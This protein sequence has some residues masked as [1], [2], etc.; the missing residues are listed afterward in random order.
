MLNKYTY[1]YYS[2]IDKAKS[3]KRSKLSKDSPRYIYY[4]SHH[5]TPISLGGSNDK[6]NLVLLTAKEHFICHLLLCKMTSGR[7]KC[8]MVN[9]L[10]K[11]QYSKS[12]GQKRYTSKSF[13]LIRTLISE[14]NSITHKGKRKSAETRKRMSES[15]KGIVFSES[16]RKNIGLATKKRLM[17][18]SYINPATTIESREKNK[19]FRLENIMVSNIMTNECKW[20]PIEELEIYIQKGFKKGNLNPSTCKGRKWFR[21]ETENKMFNEGEQPEGWV[22]GR[23]GWKENARKKKSTA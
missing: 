17:E 11:M 13:S 22:P 5:I 3:E 2:I 19:K 20:I 8:K 10:I 16:H 21:N 15:K 12:N 1:W 9:A 18:G 4:E 7:E 14:K 6:N 23:I